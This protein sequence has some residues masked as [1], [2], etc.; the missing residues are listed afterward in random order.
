MAFSTT[1]CRA[2]LLADHEVVRLVGLA[3]VCADS[4]T[5]AQWWWSASAT[6]LVGCTVP[7]GC[8]GGEYTE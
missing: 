3:A 2:S 1:V 5:R 7:S 8:S 4:R 6:A